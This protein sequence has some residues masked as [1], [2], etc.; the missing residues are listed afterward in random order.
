M[1]RILQYPDVT[2]CTETLRVNLRIQ[3]VVQ[4]A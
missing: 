1:V 4:L 3:Y 2:G